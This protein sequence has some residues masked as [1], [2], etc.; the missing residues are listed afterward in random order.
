M[1]QTPTDPPV[2][3]ADDPGTALAAAQ[4]ELDTMR[5]SLAGSE[6]G[7]ALD[8]ALLEAG[9]VDLDSA[10]LIAASVPDSATTDPAKLVADLKRRKPFLFNTARP[11]TSTA[12]PIVT[13]SVP[14]D[15][16]ATHARA[17]GDRRSLLH[18]LRLRRTGPS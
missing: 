6:R 2:S 18:Y 17:T 8:R 3:P 13:A 5:A 10:A 1:S 11:T 12:A 7:R 16:A 4:R 14:I 15:E 9:A